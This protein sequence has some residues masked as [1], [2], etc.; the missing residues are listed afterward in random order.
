[1]EGKGKKQWKKVKQDQLIDYHSLPG[2]LKDNEFI[3]G[4]Y[5]SELPLKQTFLSNF[6]IH[7]E[8]LNVWTHLMGFFIFLCLTIYT[9][10]KIPNVID[11][12]SLQQFSEMLK[13]IDLQ[14]IQA[15]LKNC[16]ASLPNMIDFHRLKD[17]H[18]P[19]DLLSSLSSLHISQ[20]LA[21]CMPEQLS[22]SN[23]RDDSVLHSVKDGMASP[24]MI[25]QPI[26][27]WPFFAFLGGAMF[28]LLA[29]STC[30]LLACHLERLRYLM[31][32][33]DYTGIVVLI[34]T[35][36][37]PPVYYTFLC[38]PFLS[39]LYLA[40]ITLLGIGTMIFSLLPAFQKPYFR[41]FRTSL[42]FAMGMSGVAPVIHKLMLYGNC[43][44]AIQTTVYEVLMGVLYGIGAFIY[45]IRV[46]ERWKPG[47]FDI[48]CSS[49]QLFHVLVDAGAYTHFHTGLIYLKWRDMERC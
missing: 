18:I 3:L 14:K 19:S 21:N 38:Q 48:V 29:S 33:I 47:N 5:R 42:Y 1:M 39:Y 20:L 4:Y 17:E 2:Y 44:E 43:S 30:H 22:I 35:S 6:R 31:L 16:I 24:L 28:Y 37:Y 26:T 40:F 7:N 25:Q 27:R 45:V 46:P 34:T 41:C 23:H 32:R 49:H 9:T 11:I 13:R 15:L 10:M 12:H 8:T 36:F